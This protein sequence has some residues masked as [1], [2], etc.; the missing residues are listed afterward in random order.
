MGYET[1]G[2]LYASIIHPVTF[3]KEVSDVKTFPK[4]WSSKQYGGGLTTDTQTRGLEQ[5]V[6]K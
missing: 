6:Q 2:Q 5:R 4:L 3:R 1:L